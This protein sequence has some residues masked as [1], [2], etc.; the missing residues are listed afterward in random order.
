MILVA[1]SL[2]GLGLF[3]WPF[4]GLG[5]PPATP[6][7]AVVAGATLVLLLV[8]AGQRRMDSR[9][10]S[11]LVALSAVDAGMR[12]A[13]VTGIGGFS[14]TFFGILCGGYVLG[15]SFGFS[16]G[17]GSLLVSAVVTGGVGPWL[18]YQMLA[19]GWVGVAAGLAGLVRRRRAP[20]RWDLAALGVVG[21]ACGIGFGICM[22]VWNWTFFRASPQL[23]WSPGLAPAVAAAHFVRYYLATSLVYDSLRALGNLAMVAAFGL[24]VLVGLRRVAVRFTLVLEPAAPGRA[25][26]VELAAGDPGPVRGRP[27]GR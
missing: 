24:P 9:Q 20:G 4:T 21:A 25:D 22:D 12:A 14:P 11:L 13:L 6:A 27:S 16:C 5:L 1:I 26:G 2:L 8:E 23:G 17:A 19:A 10:L 3:L 15:P 7:L 18:P